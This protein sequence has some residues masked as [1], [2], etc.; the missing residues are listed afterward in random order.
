M[1]KSAFT[2]PSGR[3]IQSDEG[4]E[5]FLP[6]ALPPITDFDPI[7]ITLAT[8][9]HTKLGQLSGIGEFIPNPDLL[10]S[11]YIR[12]EAVLSSKIE[13]TQAIMMDIF[14]YEAKGKKNS[15]KAADEKRIG[16]VLNYID[17]LS[18]CL[19]RVETESVSIKMIKDAHGILMKNVRGQEKTPGEFRK[20][21][22]WIG[23]QGSQIDDA[24]Y[25]PPAPEKLHGVLLDFEKFIQSPSPGIPV[26]IQCAL[27]HYQFESIHPFA[28]G[29]GRI[30]RL[31]IPL[32][33]AERKLLSRPLLYLSVYF[34]KNRSEYYHH[35][36]SVSQNQTWI[37]WI[38]FFLKGVII[39]ATDAIQNIRHL[40]DLRTIYENRL[41]SAKASG[42]ATRLMPYLFANPVV[43]IPGAKRFLNVTYPSAKLAV[44]RLQKIGILEEIGTSERNK[45][46]KATEILN[47]LT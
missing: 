5:T 23:Q 1:D 42:S 10:I 7:T 41:R 37:E 36:L 34:E 29:N 32:I 24:V 17:S 35:L 27:A 19:R 15:Q 31:L 8:E 14:E 28:D 6:N 18:T 22:N 26:L 46:F 40:T 4:N 21:Q 43:T 12:R 9:A 3:F 45:M 20:I 11:P 16:E 30:G 44:G 13:G 25:V 39:Q 47:I 2:K 33:L 38:Q